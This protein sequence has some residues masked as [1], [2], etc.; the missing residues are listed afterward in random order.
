[1]RFRVQLYQKIMKRSRN[2]ILGRGQFVQLGILEIKIT[3]A[4]RAFHVGDGMAHHTAESCLRLRAM[5]DLLNGSVH[6]SAVEHSR[7]VAATAPF[8]G[9]GA[10]RVLH[11]FNALAIPL[12]VER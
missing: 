5:H 7:I 12:I 4:H 10:D 6:K 2:R 1:M 9:L 11:V 3:L 8:R